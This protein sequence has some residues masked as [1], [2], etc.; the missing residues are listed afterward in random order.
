MTSLFKLTMF[1]SFII[2]E[3]LNLMFYFT[4][5]HTFE[6]FVLLLFPI[7]PV[8]TSA[9][10]VNVRMASSSS[11]ICHGVGPLVELFQSHVGC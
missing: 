8:C 2:L 9:Y 10:C 11:Y 5:G 7:L 6:K 1:N 3:F 4:Y